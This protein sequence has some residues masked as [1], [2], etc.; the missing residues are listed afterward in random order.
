MRCSRARRLASEATGGGAGGALSAPRRERLR[1]HL[2]SCEACRGSALGKERLWAALSVA[3][4]L[5]DRD[6]A[7]IESVLA[8]AVARQERSS[9]VEMAALLSALWRAAAPVVYGSLVVAGLIPIIGKSTGHS[10]ALLLVGGAAAGGACSSVL[11]LAASRRGSASA[12]V[13]ALLVHMGLDP[14]RIAV[15]GILAA[16][17]G[18]FFGGV[19][20]SAW[21]LGVGAAA[22]GLLAGGVIGFE[23]ER[24]LMAGLLAGLSGAALLGPVAALDAMPAPWLLIVGRAALAAAGLAFGALC[25]GLIIRVFKDRLRPR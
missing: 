4:S 23:E 15:A 18:W 12:S 24:P 16:V 20:P 6:A 17:A 10:P 5:P 3:P 8:G 7:R 14:L 22:G 9:T 1:R 19:F 13:R 21:G 11:R 25:A 2:D